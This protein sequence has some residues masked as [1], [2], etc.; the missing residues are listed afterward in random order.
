[1]GKRTKKDGKKKL[2]KKDFMAL[3]VVLVL[4]MIVYVP[5]LYESSLSTNYHQEYE[6][7]IVRATLMPAYLFVELPDGRVVDVR[8]HRKNLR[9]IGEKVI[10]QEMQKEGIESTRFR[11]VRNVKD[12]LGR[13]PDPHLFSF[14]FDF[15]AHFSFIVVRIPPKHFFDNMRHLLLLFQHC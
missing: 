7:V 14:L 4:M 5:Y 9:K 6:A 13:G 11:F 8:T 10:V 3:F 12:G 2:T 1:M 15:F